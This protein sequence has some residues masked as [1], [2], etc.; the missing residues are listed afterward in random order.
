MNSKML[1]AT[2]GYKDLSFDK[3]KTSSWYH[4]PI[5]ARPTPATRPLVQHTDNEKFY[6][7]E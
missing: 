7:H 3:G 6:L 2:Y 4:R 5:T 1:A